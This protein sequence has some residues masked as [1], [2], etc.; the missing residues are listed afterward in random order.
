MA[1]SST[2]TLREAPQGSH[3]VTGVAE[4]LYRNGHKPTSNAIEK[5]V[6]SF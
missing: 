6:G 1:A 4:I 5:A 3:Y 2:L